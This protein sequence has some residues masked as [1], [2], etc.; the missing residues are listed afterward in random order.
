MKIGRSTLSPLRNLENFFGN[1]L[2][3]GLDAL[4]TGDFDKALRSFN[5]SLE[6]KPEYV[7]TYAARAMLY[8]MQGDLDAALADALLGYNIDSETPEIN[9]VLGAIYYEMG[10]FGN[11]HRHY[12]AYVVMVDAAESEPPIM[13][14]MFGGNSIALAE[15]QIAK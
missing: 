6:T 13:R 7:A 5:D 11:S 10:Q 2:A 1:V 4:M 3:V 14:V 12:Q 15:A 8:I 9:F